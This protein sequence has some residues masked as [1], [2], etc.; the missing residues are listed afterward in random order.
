MQ[1]TEYTEICIKYLY[2]M[3][4]SG[5]KYR[6]KCIGYKNVSDRAYTLPFRF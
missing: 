6:N 5:K 3:I 2:C 1:Y 4:K